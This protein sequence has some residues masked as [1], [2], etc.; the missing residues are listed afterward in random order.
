MLALEQEL[1]DPKHEIFPVSETTATR[2]PSSA[3]G[4]SCSTPKAVALYMDDTLVN[5]TD[6]DSFSERNGGKPSY[7]KVSL[8]S[9]SK[10]G[11]S[12]SCWKLSGLWT[13]SPE[14]CGMP[15]MIT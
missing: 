4:R 7:S 14:S 9:L 13:A 8:T 6:F 11:T 5:M 10:F 1:Y 12:G 2:G 3:V 15:S